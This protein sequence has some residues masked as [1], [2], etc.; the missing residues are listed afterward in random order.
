MNPVQ[1]TATI[2]ST[3]K[4]ILCQAEDSFH[5]SF[6]SI[7]GWHAFTAEP[8]SVDWI[9]E[10]LR[11]SLIS[12]RYVRLLPE[13]WDQALYDEN[14]KQA[15]Q[16]NDELFGR[17][18]TQFGYR[19]KQSVM[20]QA[21]MVSVWWQ[22]SPSEG[23]SI[24]A[25]NHKRGGCEALANDPKHADKLVELSFGSS[26]QEIGAAVRRML[27]VSTISGEESAA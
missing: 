4:F 16:V 10:N 1:V 3:E 21:L 23:L 20:A 8:A 7:K 13:Q 14:R 18:A 26:D 2:F 12:A 19:R 24:L 11:R 15:A 6:P 5:S 22:K 27:S 9:G 25:M 17:I